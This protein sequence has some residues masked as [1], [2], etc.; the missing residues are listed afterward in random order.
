MYSEQT[1][2]EL[3]SIIVLGIFAQWLAWRIKFPSILFLLIF[4]FIAGPVSGFLH[5]DR[6]MGNLLFPVVSIS[7]AVILFE[8][9]MTL[10]I[11]ELRDIGKVVL[12]LITLGALVTWVFTAASAYYLLKLNLQLSV[13][14]GAIL[15]VTGPTVVGPLLRFIRPEKKVGS[16]LNWEGIVIDPIGALLAVLVFEAISAGQFREMGSFVILG[17]V[18]TIFFGG[19]IGYLMARFLVLFLKRFWIPDFLQETVALVLVITAFLVSNYFQAE[20]GLLAVT[21]MGLALDNQKQVSIKHIVQ[22]KE[23]LRVLIISS[24]FILLAARLQ[25]SDF[26]RFTVSSVIFIAVLIF[27]VRPLSIWVATLGSDLKWREKLFISWVA[28]RGIVAAAIASIFGLELS[29]IAFPQAE[30]LSPLVFLVIVSTVAV[31]G[32]TAAPVAR[33]LKLAQSNPQGIFIMGAHSWACEIA[34]VLLDKNFKVA[35]IDTNRVKISKARLEG[36]PAYHGNVLAEHTLDEID[37]DGIGRF[38]ALTSNDEANSLAALN[39]SELF[40]SQEVYQLAPSGLKKGEE[41]DKSS[42]KYLRGRTLF[43]DGLNYNYLNNR[44]MTGWTIK[45][46]KLSEEF[47]YST[48]QTH[49]NDSAIPLFLVTENEQLLVFTADEKQEPKAGQTIIALVKAEK[50]TI[51]ASGKK[52][53]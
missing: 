3:A 25:F 40:E 24:L 21:I 30:Y 27:G 9:G 50:E 19:L 48:F 23:N 7:V 16:I 52:E 20:S 6:L 53:D 14:I 13:L 34:K 39:F 8:G 45:S 41:S 37:L 28:P 31:Y 35:L 43:G 49:Y 22:F 38:F 17:I 46:T 11:G 47:D 15:V 51:S 36:I 33:W 26:T 42:P 1:L 44:F 10:R 29:A 2:I 12:S 18:K 4:G 5:P 32:L